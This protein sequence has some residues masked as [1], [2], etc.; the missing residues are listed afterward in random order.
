M[1]DSR[2]NLSNI[3]SRMLPVTLYWTVGLIEWVSL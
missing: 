3:C 1:N 2:D